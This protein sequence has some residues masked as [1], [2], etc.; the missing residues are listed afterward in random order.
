MEIGDFVIQEHTLQRD[1]DDFS[2]TGLAHH[3]R[4]PDA[5]YT[6]QI[7]DKSRLTAKQSIKL[8]KIRKDPSFSI[9]EWDKTQLYVFEKVH[10]GV[11]L[12]ALLDLKGSF[13]EGEAGI[14]LGKVAYVI[15]LMY[16]NRAYPQ[17]FTPTEILIQFKTRHDYV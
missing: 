17:R 1:P 10:E 4:E 9:V 12:A 11:S 5:F 6:C 7:I 2:W 15:R 3:K 14:I 8:H 13:R 16:Q